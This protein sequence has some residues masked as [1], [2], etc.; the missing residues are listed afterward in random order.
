MRLSDAA[1]AGGTGAAGATGS[2]A[3]AG[4]VCS[5]AGD[6]GAG[7]V[8]DVAN[9]EW[10]VMVYESLDNNLPAEFAHGPSLLGNAVTATAPVN[11]VWLSATPAKDSRRW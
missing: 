6:G 11:V 8:G 7:C 3:A 1:T 4:G 9:A 5:G 2:A 10:T